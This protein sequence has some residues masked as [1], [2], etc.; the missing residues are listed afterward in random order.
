MDAD[1][2]LLPELVEEIKGL[3]SAPPPGIVGYF[4]K[5]RVMFMDR[6]IRHGTYYPVWFLRLWRKGFARYEQREMDEH[7]ILNGEAGYLEND[8]VDHN[9]SG[10]GVWTEKH[11]KYAQR[12]AAAYLEHV[13]EAVSLGGGQAE[14]KRWLKNNVYYR[15]PLFL[16][17]FLYWFYRYF[18]R[19]GFLDG[20]EGMIFHFL[21]GFWYRFLIDAKICERKMK[22]L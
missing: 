13:K 20:K 14:S 16:R 4:I 8:L 22:K 17:A 3:L 15:M 5:R 7:A 2:Y 1:E 10:L 19:L 9:L 21:Q 18:I 11:N 6:W 12:E